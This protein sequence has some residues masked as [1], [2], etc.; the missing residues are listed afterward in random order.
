MLTAAGSTVATS[1]ASRPVAAGAVG[2][3]PVPVGTAVGRRRVRERFERVHGAQQRRRVGGAGV[4][5]E[6]LVRDKAEVLAVD[7]PRVDQR[8]VLRGL[9]FVPHGGG[10]VARCGGGVPHGSGGE[11]RRCGAEPLSSFLKIKM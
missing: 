6:A 11:A 9:D 4:L 7:G 5:G 3:G 1:W 2:T 10:F 8:L